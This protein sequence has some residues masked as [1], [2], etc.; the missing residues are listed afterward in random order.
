MMADDVMNM[1]KEKHSF[2]VNM[3][4]EKHSF[5]AGGSTTWCHYYKNQ[6]E[7][8]QKVKNKSTTC[9]NNITIGHIR[10]GPY[11]LL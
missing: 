8:S 10:K 1:G 11:I 2:I 7:G 5:I 3:G 9:P 6:C 4:K